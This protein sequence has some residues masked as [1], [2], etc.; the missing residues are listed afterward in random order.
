VGILGPEKWDPKLATLCSSPFFGNFG[1]ETST[2]IP[3]RIKNVFEKKI[4]NKKTEL[5]PKLPMPYL[6][7]EIF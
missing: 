3:F 1:F 6:L 2:K 5:P 7:K 4:K